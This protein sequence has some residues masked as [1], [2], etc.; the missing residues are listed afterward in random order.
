M[1]RLRSRK[2]AEPYGLEVPS[3]PFVECRSGCDVLQARICATY[4]RAGSHCHS[5]TIRDLGMNTQGWSKKKES[6]MI[7]RLRLPTKE[8]LRSHRSTAGQSSWVRS[9]PVESPSAKSWPL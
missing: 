1:E 2:A 4:R 3:M 5:I 7:T 6:H 8:R 9:S